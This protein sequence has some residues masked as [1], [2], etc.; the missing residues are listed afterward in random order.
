MLDNVIILSLI[1]GAFFTGKFISDKYHSRIYTEYENFKSEYEYLIRLNAAQH[2]VGYVAP[3]RRVK[4]AP[5]GEDFMVRLKENGRAT[6][7]ITPPNA[8]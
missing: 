5:I 7:Q 2:G 4:Q 3:P 1:T 8:R 6:Q